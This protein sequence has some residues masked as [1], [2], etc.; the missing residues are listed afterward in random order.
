MEL[1]EFAEA[2]AAVDPG[3]A[4]LLGCQMTDEEKKRHY[5]KRL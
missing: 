5:G 3:E 4:K 2:L 1:Q